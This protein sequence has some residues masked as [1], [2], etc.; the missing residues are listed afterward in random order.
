MRIRTFASVFV[1]TWLLSACASAPG[2]SDAVQLF[3]SNDTPRFHAYVACTSNTVN[4]A[5]VG[6]AF[7]S[8]AGDRRVSLDT[9]SPDDKAFIAGTPS[10]AAERTLPYRLAVRYATDMSAPA[11]PMGGGSMTPMISYVA[12]V[13]V[14]DASTGRLL[15]TMSFKDKILIDQSGGTAN[16]YINAQVRGLLKHVDAG[17]AGS[18]A[19]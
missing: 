12:T 6:R 9:V 10:P 8:W 5:I 3:G 4:C 2:T 1:G 18:S 13:Q 14:F 7:D 19:S 11:N 15:K 16:P 17:Y